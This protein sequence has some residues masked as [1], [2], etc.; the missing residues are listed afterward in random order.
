MDSLTVDIGTKI[1]PADHE[2]YVARPGGRYKLYG[3][4]I[5]SSMVFPELPMLDLQKGL[6]IDNQP[7]LIRRVRR[8]SAIRS[9]HNSSRPED[10]L[11]DRNLA[12]Y[13]DEDSA[14]VS[15]FIGVL[16]G[17]FERAK[18]GDLVIVPPSA[19]SQ[20]CF[21]GE[22]LTHPTE[23]R[24]HRV[25]KYGDDYLTARSVKWLAQIT[26]RALP[27]TVIEAIEKPT[28]FFLLDKPSRKF[29][30]E[31][32]YGSYTIGNQFNSRFEVASLTFKTSDDLLIQAFFNFIAN[33]TIAVSEGHL[34]N[35]KSFDESIFVDLGDF[36]PDLRTNVNSPGFLNLSGTNLTPIVASVMLI[37]AVAIGPSAVQAAETGKLRIGNISAPLDD[38][39][40]A[41]IN[42]QV[43]TQ[44]KLLGL[45]K[46]TKACERARLA[47]KRTGLK[48][49]ATITTEN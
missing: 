6:S 47:Q 11:P 28:I 12:A 44:L 7:D 49:R 2:V 25:D 30:Y 17:Y 48:G 38:P 35:I 1:L 13:K 14:S 24:H 33:N 9:W 29:I 23:F 40:T 20:E 15:Q 36:A 42:H 8:S 27:V 18:K 34:D 10:N 5:A 37:I 45:D 31:K 3:S 19:Y 4:V 21:I 43:L 16:R 46:W 22:F 41:E 32:A 39:C 26:K